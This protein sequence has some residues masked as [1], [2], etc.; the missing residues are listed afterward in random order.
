MTTDKLQKFKE[1]F[2]LTLRDPKLGKDRIKKALS[3][4]EQNLHQYL[5]LWLAIS[6]DSQFVY[7]S[8]GLLFTPYDYLTYSSL[9]MLPQETLVK[10]LR[11]RRFFLEMFNHP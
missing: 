8:Q 1:D 11:L 10:T 7:P 6:K 5:A 3:N 2:F 4:P 9:Q